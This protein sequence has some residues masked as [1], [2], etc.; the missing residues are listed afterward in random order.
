MASRDIEQQLNLIDVGKMFPYNTYHQIDKTDCDECGDEHIDGVY[1]EGNWCLKCFNKWQKSRGSIDTCDI[2]NTDCKVSLINYG[3]ITVVTCYQCRSLIK[4][5]FHQLP[6]QSS[7]KPKR[8]KRGIIFDLSKNVVH[9]IDIQ[10]G[11]LT[12]KKKS[13]REISHNYMFNRFQALLIRRM[14]SLTDEKKRT[15]FQEMDKVEIFDFSKKKKL[16]KKWFGFNTISSF[17]INE[18]FDTIHLLLSPPEACL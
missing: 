16:L 2:C 3:C 9:L 14:K 5:N 18:G 11:E 10:E 17:H 8:R 6:E 12:E 4:D 1:Q 7:P 13:L 15:A